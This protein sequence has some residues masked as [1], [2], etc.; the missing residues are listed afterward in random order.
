M[1]EKLLK[2]IKMIR[3]KITRRKERNDWNL[4]RFSEQL[5]ESLGMYKV[6]KCTKY[7]TILEG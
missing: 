1:M 3:G 6:K 7:L 5:L 2:C 4:S